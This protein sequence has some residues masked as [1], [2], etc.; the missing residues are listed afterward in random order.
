MWLNNFGHVKLKVGVAGQ[1]DP[2]RLARIRKVLGRKI[3]VRLDANEAWSPD[4]V[5][6][7][8]VSLQRRSL[9]TPTRR[10]YRLCRCGR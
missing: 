7:R 4:E 9:A 2:K 3:D 8:V 1:D 6:G 10:P 5:I